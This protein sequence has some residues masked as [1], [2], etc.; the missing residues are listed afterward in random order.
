MNYTNMLNENIS[1]EVIQSEVSPDDTYNNNCE[2]YNNNCETYNNNDDSFNC[3]TFV[4]KQLDYNVNYIMNDLKKIA[5][6]YEINY[7]KL[8]K[9]ELIQEIVIYESDPSNSN[10]YMKRLQAWYWLKELKEDP[11]LKQFIL[12]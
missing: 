2:T 4:A 7:R 8:K 6:Y 11:K 3:D 5:D 10:T 1:I 12:F 9:D